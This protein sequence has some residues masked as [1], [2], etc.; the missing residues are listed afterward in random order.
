[1]T[2]QRKATGNVQTSA[3][4]TSTRNGA[5]SGDAS[6]QSLTVVT[7]PAD[8]GATGSHMSTQSLTRV[9]VS[10][11]RVDTHSHMPTQPQT[12]VAVP[13]ELMN[14]A[15]SAATRQLSCL[16]GLQRQLEVSPAT[17]T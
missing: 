10:A 12:V 17:G 9:T 13:N 16:L 6:T 15:P 11:Q 8:R 2:V 1:M 5:P 3:N 4:Q 14:M 7:V